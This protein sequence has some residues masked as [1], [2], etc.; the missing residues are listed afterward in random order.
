MWHTFAAQTL[1]TKNMKYLRIP[2]LVLLAFLLS[3]PSKADDSNKTKLTVRNE[4]F[5]GVNSG[6]VFRDMLCNATLEILHAE[7]LIAISLSGI[8]DADIYLLDNLNQ[9]VEQITV[10][11]GETMNYL[12][13]PSQ[14]GSYTIVIW[15]MNYYGEASF[16]IE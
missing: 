6:E 1:K 7:H 9:V 10:H 15:S 12:D 5:T 14:P 2:F 3:P 4:S 13:L 11:E 8:G 16:I